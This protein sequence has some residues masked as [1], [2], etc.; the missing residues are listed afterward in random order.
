VKSVWHWFNLE[1]IPNYTSPTYMEADGRVARLARISIVPGLAYVI[2]KLFYLPPFL[3]SL[4]SIMRKKIQSGYALLCAPL[5]GLW[6]V[7][8]LAFPD[9]R[10]KSNA[11]MVVLPAILAA[12]WV[13]RRGESTRSRKTAPGG[14]ERHEDS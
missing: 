13:W 14:A 1:K 9:T 10:F 12:Y 8:V 2:Y 4:I 11:E 6:P 3:F 7:V 5:L